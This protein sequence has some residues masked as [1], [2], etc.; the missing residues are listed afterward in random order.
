MTAI[1][2][3]FQ[4]SLARS[5]R[6]VCM[7][8]WLCSVIFQFSLARSVTPWITSTTSPSFLSILSCEIRHNHTLL[9]AWQRTRYHY[10]QFSLARSAAVS[11]WWQRRRL[12]FQFSLARSGNTEFNCRLGICFQFSLARSVRVLDFR[13]SGGFNLFQFSLARSEPTRV[14]LTI[15]VEYSFQFSLARS[16]YTGI[17]F[18]V[19][20][21]V[22]LSILSCEIRES[23]N[24]GP[25]TENRKA[26]NS[27]LRDQITH[28]SWSSSRGISNFQFSLARSENVFPDCGSP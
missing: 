27:L 23:S 14:R 17:R 28:L 13:I 3:S 4:F 25:N 22:K 9:H 21:L 19:Q 12:H 2:V 24:E 20:E 18:Q 10:F 6:E 8:I 26:F 7:N 11:L 15:H 1:P 16:G 5:V